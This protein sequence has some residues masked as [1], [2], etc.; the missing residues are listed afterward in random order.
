MDQKHKKRV[1]VEYIQDLLK[2]IREFNELDLSNIEL[3]EDG[4]PLVIPDKVLEAWRHVGMTNA[5]FID[6]EFWKS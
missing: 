6:L 1:S 2:S 3:I 5:T 4:M